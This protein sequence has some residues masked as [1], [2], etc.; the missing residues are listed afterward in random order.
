VLNAVQGE[1]LESAPKPFER[2]SDTE[3]ISSVALGPCVSDCCQL[4][5]LLVIEV[6]C[7]IRLKIIT[8]AM[9]F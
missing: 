2:G 5:S 6:F 4:N 8:F 1:N 9:Y 7:L 3:C